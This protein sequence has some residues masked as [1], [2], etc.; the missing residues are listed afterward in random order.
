[1]GSG[2]GGSASSLLHPPG[3][4][5]TGTHT[6]SPNSLAAP[7]NAAFVDKIDP[8][9]KGSLKRK[10]KKSQGSSRYRLTSDVEL[11]QLPLLKGK[12]NLATCMT[13]QVTMPGE[14][15]VCLLSSLVV[16]WVYLLSAYHECC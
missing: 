15:R 6:S 2:S 5:G 8:Y 14:G 10:Q 11:Q 3:S 16:L 13:E 4:A 12:V 7:A 9:K 1:M